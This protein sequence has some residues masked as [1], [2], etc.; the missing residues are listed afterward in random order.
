ML[1]IAFT[2]SLRGKNPSIAMSTYNQCKKYIDENFSNPQISPSLVAEK[3]CINVRYMSRLF[4]NIAD[5]QPRQYIDRLKLNKAVSLLLKTNLSV[6]QIA[7]SI[8]YL[9]QYHFSRNFKKAYGLSPNNFRKRHIL[10]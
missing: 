3:C 5:I 4:K 8:G 6:G 1:E 7:Y 2:A 10:L 9:D